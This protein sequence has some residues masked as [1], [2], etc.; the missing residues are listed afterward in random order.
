MESALTMLA[1]LVLYPVLR[2]LL[3]RAVCK[4]HA[5]RAL[6]GPALFGVLAFEGA[7]GLTIVANT[8]STVFLSA[9]RR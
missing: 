1:L 4:E 8:K 7:L 9:L 2:R 3:R 5:H 6:L